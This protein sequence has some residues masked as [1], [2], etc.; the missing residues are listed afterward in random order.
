METL[1]AHTHPSRLPLHPPPLHPSTPPPSTRPPLDP[2]PSTLH[3]CRRTAPT[4]AARRGT[5]CAPCATATTCRACPPRCSACCCR[6]P[7][8]SP[9]TSYRA[10]PR[11]S[12]PSIAPPHAQSVATPLA[13]P[14]RGSCASS[15]RAWRLQ[16]AR[17]S[18]GEAG[19]PGGQPPPRLLEPAAPQTAPQAAPQAA[20]APAFDHAGLVQEHWR[21]K[22]VFEPFFAWQ[23]PQP[24]RR[25]TPASVT[26]PTADQFGVGGAVH[27]RGFL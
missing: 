24:S 15:R 19:L 7:R 2:R 22:K 10:S 18:Q 8:A 25:P 17:H 11:S 9:P 6:A 20:D 1:Q 3:P 12:G 14:Q 27:L 4:S 26:P 5:C 16:A 21:A 23:A 13:A